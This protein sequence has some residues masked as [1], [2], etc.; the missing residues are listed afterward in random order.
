MSD[1]I[2]LT[3]ASDILIAT[4]TGSDATDRQIVGRANRIGRDVTV[5]L[6]VT[7]FTYADSLESGYLGEQRSNYTG[8]ANRTIASIFT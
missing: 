2:T 4:P 1:G 7:R 6:R 5:P 8:V 3:R